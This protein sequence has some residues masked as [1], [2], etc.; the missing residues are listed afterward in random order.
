M[1]KSMSENCSKLMSK[2]GKDVQCDCCTEDSIEGIAL[3]LLIV[4]DDADI[5]FMHD[6][7]AIV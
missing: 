5:S 2:T 7:F 4:K 1:Q 6:C 3:K